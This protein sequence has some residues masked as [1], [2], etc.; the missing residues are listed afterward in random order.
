MKVIN[1]VFETVDYNAFKII[2]GNRN[3]NM[4]H[5]DKLKKS[6]KKKYIPVPIVINQ[7]YQIIDGQHRFTACQELGYPV[8]YIIIDDLKLKDVQTLNTNSMN[9]TP[10]QYMESYCELGYEE[11]IKYREF[12]NTYKLC[13]SDTRSLLTGKNV[14][15]GAG[16]EDFNNGFLKV[17]HLKEATEVGEKLLQV[18][19]HYGNYAKQAFVKALQICLNNPEYNHAS[20]VTRVSNKKKHSELDSA[21]DYKD[22]LRKI[23]SIYN[24]K[25]QQSEKTRLTVL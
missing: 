25:R 24:Y 18:G 14:G 22:M 5:V 7:D 9:W 16:S 12:K 17:T 10:Q 21:T 1:Q 19:V 8:S 2:E 20:F 6:M 11:Y 13:H 23:E 3:I 4:L 15:G